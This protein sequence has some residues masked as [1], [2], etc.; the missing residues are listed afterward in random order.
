MKSAA[1]S[2][3]PRSGVRAGTGWMRLLLDMPFVGVGICEPHSLRW[4]HVNER[5]CALVGRRRDEL[6]RMTWHDLCHAGDLVAGNAALKRLVARR[7]A[8]VRLSIR[9]LHKDGSPVL[10]EVDFTRRPVGGPLIALVSPAPAQGEPAA[11]PTAQSLFRDAQTPMI[12]LEAGTWSVIEANPAAERFYGWSA[13][14]MRRLN[15]HVWDV[16]STDRETVLGR[17]REAAA[18]KTGLFEG[19]HRTAGG[20]SRDVEVHCGPMMVRGRA[21]VYGIVHDRTEI[22]RA[23]AA[24]REAEET[25]HAVVEQSIVG[26]YILE[27]GRFQY[28]NRRMCEI[29]GYADGELAGRPTLD[30]VAPADRDMVAENQ[31]R[32]FSGEIDGLQ[33]EFRGLRRDGALIDVGAHGNVTLLHGKRVIIGVAQDIT[34]RRRAERHVEEFHAKTQAAMRGAVGALSRMVDLRDPYTA[35]HERRVAGLAETVARRLGITEDDVRAV[36]IAAQVHDIG[37]ISVPSEILTKPARLLPAEF[38]IIKL[39]APNGRD[40]LKTVDFPWPVADMVGQHHE[41]LDGSGY[42]HGRKDAEICAGARILAVADT[43]EAMSSHRPYRA[44]LGIDPALAEIE[45]GSGSAYDADVAACV[46]RLFRD[47][48]YRIPD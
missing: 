16:S 15:L 28:A 34:E 14:Q 33:Y 42:P 39:H 3:T 32:R 21:C 43:V 26:I 41:R 36:G 48:G 9:L 19:V 20:E 45:R 40:I 11:E 47:E 23:D 31:R 12:V 29:F 27:D 13:A 24:R 30:V 35:G 37:K 2:S 6:L 25:L 7:A 5:L 10:A 38:E 8:H 18:G 17:L 44:S 1:T 46:L 22:R 4:T